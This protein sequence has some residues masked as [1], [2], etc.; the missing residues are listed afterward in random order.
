[1]SDSLITKYRPQT[2]DEVVGHAVVIKALKKKLGGSTRSFLFHGPSGTGKTTMARIVAREFGCAS[3]Y[4]MEVDA[5]TNNGVEHARE[6][7]DHLRYRPM[8]KNACRAVI[9]DEAHMMTKAAWNALLKSLEDVPK[10]VVWLICTTEVDKL[11]P[12]VK[13]RCYQVSLSALPVVQLKRIL[14]DVSKS[15][16]IKLPPDIIELI[17]KESRGSPRQA[18]SYLDACSSAETVKEAAILMESAIA[19][20]NTIALCRLLV[21]RNPSWAEAM[22]IVGEMKSESP[23]GVRIVVCNYVAAILKKSKGGRET[24]ALL[25][26]LEAFEGTYNQSEKFAPLLLSIGRVIFQ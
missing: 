25:T 16:K 7:Q 17:A 5:A 22:K 14:T 20:D 13:S 4:I 19:S 26:I 3:D 9:L 12:T 2:L 1:M 24:A 21:G 6:I 15:E 18:L 11:L 23:E 8:G 10:H